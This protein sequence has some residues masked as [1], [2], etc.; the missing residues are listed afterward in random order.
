MVDKKKPQ[1]KNV[2]LNCNHCRRPVKVSVSCTKCFSIYHPACM[3]QSA[4]LKS[5]ECIHEAQCSQS[6]VMSEDEYEESREITLLKRIIRELE[7]KNILLQENNMLLREKVEFLTFTNSTNQRRPPLIAGSFAEAL[8]STG[9][10]ISP[11][12]LSRTS[13]EKI[14]DVQ[15]VLDKK[16]GDTEPVLN[17]LSKSREECHVP[18]VQS[19]ESGNMERRIDGLESKERWTTVQRKRRKNPQLTIIGNQK[20]QGDSNGEGLKTAPKKAFL[21]VSRLHSSTESTD[22]ST[23]LKATFPEIECEKLTSKFPQHYSSFKVT[24]DF[25]NLEKAMD[26]SIWPH[27]CFVTRFFHRKT[28][29]TNVG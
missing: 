5:A 12:A 15:P 25:L 13:A 20:V 16:F 9:N 4:E 24:I 23:F 6:E 21:Y 11:K 19:R 18:R 29:E 28:K 27:G 1:E 2:N 3:K 7:E 10:S 22:V 14:S 26:G 8:A 17:G